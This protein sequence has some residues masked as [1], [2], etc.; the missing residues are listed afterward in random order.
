MRLRAPIA[1]DVP[2]VQA[3]LTACAARDEDAPLPP[4]RS[5]PPVVRGAGDELTETCVLETEAGELVGYAWA[6]SSGSGA[7]VAP[8]A[9]GR[10][11]GRRLLEWIE[12]RERAAGQSVHRQRVAVTNTSAEALLG[13]AGYEAPR[14]VTRMARELHDLPPVPA[15]PRGFH[16][17]PVEPEGD[18][19]PLHALD[20]RCFRDASDYEP[21]PFEHFCATHL[22]APDADPRLSAVAERD[23][24]MAAFLLARRWDE[25]GIGHISLLGVAPEWRRRGLARGLLLGAF[26]GFA[27]AGLQVAQLNVTSDDP[28]TRVL[29]EQVGMTPRFA[30]RTWARPVDAAQRAGGVH[31]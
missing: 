10:G 2:A 31:A 11:H 26:A 9:E 24:R 28:G 8:S 25:G 20:D 13:A 22:H 30:S 1:A 5:P 17:R 19:V 4:W 15:L 16:A 21:D 7:R 27:A 18:A 12:E 29:Y 14:E 23:G 3:I 6:A